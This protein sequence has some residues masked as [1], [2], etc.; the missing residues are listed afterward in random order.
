MNS[1]ESVKKS[2]EILEKNEIE[3]ALLHTTNLYPTP[4]NLVRLGG[5]QELMKTFPG[6]PVGLS[7]HTTDN[8]SSY[9]AITLGA[10]ILERHFTDSMDRVGPDIICS[11]DEKKCK[12]LID[13]SKI[14]KSMLGGK[15]EP[16]KEE[17]VTINFAFST[18]VSIKNISEGDEFTKDNIW[19][20]RPGT[21]EI[22]AEFYNDVLGKYSNVSIKS[23][24]HIKW[25]YCS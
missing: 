15:K 19:V 25:S 6:I 23:G 3:Y 16:A 14:I 12:E 9:S 2:V 18:V 11:M 20:K 1:I 22:K 4:H 7:D 17:K 21:G 8:L 24:E 5:M 13:N 10:S